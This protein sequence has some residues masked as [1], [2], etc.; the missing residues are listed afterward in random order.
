MPSQAPSRVDVPSDPRDLA[1]EFRHRREVEVR[2]RDT[3]AL[4]HVNNVVYLTYCELA[5]TSYWRDVLGPDWVPGRHPERGLILAESRIVHRS[6]TFFGESVVVETRT[7][8][9]GRS[10]FSQEHRLTAGES[11]LGRSRLLAVASAVLVGYDYTASRPIPLEQDVVAR[12]EAFEGRRL[13]P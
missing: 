7:V 3:N 8:A 4:G 13:R 11:D 5:R 2:L 12:L 9:I 6:P 10:S 1:G